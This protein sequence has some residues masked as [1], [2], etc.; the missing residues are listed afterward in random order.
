METHNCQK[1]LP[2]LG[3]TRRKN[4]VVGTVLD[5]LLGGRGFEVVI[6]EANRDIDEQ[7]H[8]AID[9]NA[10]GGPAAGDVPDKRMK[11]RAMLTALCNFVNE[12]RQ[13]MDVSG[14][15]RISCF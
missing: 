4:I 13:K 9:T 6:M 7:T 5:D 2:Q 11:L 10:R 14:S 1:L 15:L 3:G 8:G 12:Y